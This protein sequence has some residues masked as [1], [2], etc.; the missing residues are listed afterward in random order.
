MPKS[1]VNAP[2]HLQDRKIKENLDCTAITQINFLGNKILFKSDFIMVEFLK[3]CR[4]PNKKGNSAG[5]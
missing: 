4:M 3:Y 5:L 1:V 2:A